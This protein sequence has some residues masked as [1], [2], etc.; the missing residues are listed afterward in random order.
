MV[1]AGARFQP[2]INLGCQNSRPTV[3]PLARLHFFFI[4]VG[5]EFAAPALK[6]RLE[7]RQ[8]SV[9]QQWLSNTICEINHTR[10]QHAAQMVQW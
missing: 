4:I 5:S 7:T 8:V 3:L 1:I 10:H 2:I 6:H 9:R